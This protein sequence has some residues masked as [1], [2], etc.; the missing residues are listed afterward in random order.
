MGHGAQVVDLVRLHLRRVNELMNEWMRFAIIISSP[1]VS[2]MSEG[3]FTQSATCTLLLMPCCVYVRVFTL[4]AHK[5]GTQLSILYIIYLC[6]IIRSTPECITAPSPYIVVT[7]LRQLKRCACSSCVF[8]HVSIHVHSKSAHTT[9][10]DMTYH[11][12]YTKAKTNKKDKA[13]NNRSN[14]NFNREL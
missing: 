5:A 11:M 7:K 4:V 14:A 1:Y 3:G 13:Q 8:V 9:G 12:Y 10:H 6:T 2:Y